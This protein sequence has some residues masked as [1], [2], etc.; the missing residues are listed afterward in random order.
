MLDSWVWG[1]WFFFF[2][3]KHSLMILKEIRKRT[4]R[5]PSQRPTAIPAQHQPLAQSSEQPPLAGTTA[6]LEKALAL[7]VQ[8]GWRLPAPPRGPHTGLVAGGSPRLPAQ[9]CLASN[10]SPGLAWPGSGGLFLAQPANCSVTLVKSPGR[11]TPSV[12]TA[13]AACYR[14]G[15]RPGARYKQAGLEVARLEVTPVSPASCAGL[16]EERLLHHTSRAARGP[17]RGLRCC[18]D[19]RPGG[20]TA[21]FL[22]R[23][24]AGPG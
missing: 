21:T 13:L 7:P 6:T 2:F 17:G 10:L 18:P 14:P 22:L 15:A 16:G 11:L 3:F 23:M 24:G 9:T 19:L 12:S 4:P 5:R 8:G 1:F 20:T